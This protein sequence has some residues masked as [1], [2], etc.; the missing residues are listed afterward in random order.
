MQSIYDY[1]QLEKV[2]AMKIFINEGSP[3]STNINPNKP[4]IPSSIRKGINFRS[5]N[6]TPRGSFDQNPFQ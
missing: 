2:K 1:G 4:E 3:N 5:Q 6:N